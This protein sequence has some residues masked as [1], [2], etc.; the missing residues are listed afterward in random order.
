MDIAFDEI[1]GVIHAALQALLAELCGRHDWKGTK[2]IG[3]SAFVVAE[4]D[5]AALPLQFSAFVGD[6][7]AIGEFAPEWTFSLTR[8]LLEGPS[9]AFEAADENSGS[10]Q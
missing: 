10:L 3:M 7:T 5:G 8:D 2:A 1:D 6:A 4:Y 9:A